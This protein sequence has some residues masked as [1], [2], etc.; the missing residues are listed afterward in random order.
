MEHKVHL[1][2]SELSSIWSSYLYNTMAARM[3]SHFEVTVEDTRV[4]AIIKKAMKLTNERIVLLDQLFEKEQIVKPIGFTEHDVNLHAPRLYSDMFYLQYILLSAK[5][6]VT[7][8]S[9][10]FANSARKDMRDMYQHFLNGSIQLFQETTDLMLDMGIFTRTP[11]MIMPKEH[12]YIKSNDFFTKNRPLTAMELAELALN[13]ETNFIGKLLLMGFSQTTKTKKIKTFFNKGIKIAEDNIVQ[14]TDVLI[15]N[16][17]ELTT[18]GASIVTDSTVAAYSEKLML[19]HIDTLNSIGMSN[20]GLSLASTTRNDLG[21]L[22]G[23]LVAIAAK[24]SRDGAELLVDHGWYEEPP[25]TVNRDKLL[26]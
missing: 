9:S 16:K 23:K 24:Y 1:T 25:T 17:T 19:F 12:S 26:K 13:I 20:F 14:L 8:Q 15:K 22:F 21:I 11:S 18:A 7:M 3:I 6:G 2:S 10:K 5:S 4:K